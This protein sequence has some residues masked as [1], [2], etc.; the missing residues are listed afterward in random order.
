VLVPQL[1]LRRHRRSSSSSSPVIIVIAV[2]LYRGEEAEKNFRHGDLANYSNLTGTAVELFCTNWLGWDKVSWV[3]SA[4]LERI[5]ETKDNQR[6]ARIA[7]TATG[8]LQ[9]SIL[10]PLDYFE[11]WIYCRFFCR[12]VDFTYGWDFVQLE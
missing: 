3:V 1:L 12:V 10:W 11:T 8:S 7:A 5:V 6:I 4:T 2:R 9:Q